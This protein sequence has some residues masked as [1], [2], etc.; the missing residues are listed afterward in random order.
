MKVK[1]RTLYRGLLAFLGMM[2]LWSLWAAGQTATNKPSPAPTNQPALLVRDLERFE[3]HPLSFG[4]DR[5]P[6]LRSVRLLD[7]PLWKYLA[8]LI[9]ILLAFYLAKLIDLA[10]RAWLK[11]VASR[12]QSSTFGRI[13]ELLRGP[14]KVVVLVILLSIGLNLFDWPP[15]ARV[16]SSNAL[17]LVVA[18]SLTYLALNTIDFLLDVWRRRKEQDPD[19]RFDDQ[20]F[21]LLRKSLKIFI[22]IVAV[23]VTAQ[24]L[25]IN[26][27]AAIT[28]LSI[29]GLAVG[30]A[31]QDTL[32][33]LFG[34]VAVFADRPFRV[35]DNIKLDGAEGAVVTVGL[36]STRVRN[37]DGF[38]VAVPNK[39]MGNAIITNQTQR[40]DIKTTM[41]LILHQD[42]PADRVRQALAILREVYGGNPMTKDVW[43]SFNEFAGA[44]LNVL[45]IHWWKGTEYQKYLA[46]IQEM[47]LAVKARF[48]A[49]QIAF[50]KL[51]FS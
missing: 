25:G 51:P 5:I 12:S 36:R 2:L 27:T 28:S 15:A 17:I 16:Y 30:L 38:L 43:I 4:L 50:A 41:K 29:G 9:Y 7:E 26:I 49:E 44:N 14:I 21:G 1:F 23:L 40:S 45:V 39:T 24:N 19:H 32:A 10:A 47:N 35:G 31:A 20:L 18:A 34:A 11:G 37:P 46:G 8:S 48:D 33:N 42:L 22:I 3:A 6:P 13:L